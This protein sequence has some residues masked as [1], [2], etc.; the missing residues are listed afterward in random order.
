METTLMV[1]AMFAVFFMGIVIG[2]IV[3]A[4]IYK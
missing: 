2:L 4:A 1:S 3:G